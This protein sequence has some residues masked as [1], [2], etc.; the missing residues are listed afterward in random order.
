MEP[1]EL[2]RAPYSKEAEMSL[3]GA[4]LLDAGVLDEVLSLVSPD[5]FYEKENKQI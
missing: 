2:D 4:I 1:F 5:D 3:L